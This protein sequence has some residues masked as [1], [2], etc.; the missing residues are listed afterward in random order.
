[1]PEV[2]G[3]RCP[4]HGRRLEWD[5]STTEAVPNR[6]GGEDTYRVT[7]YACPQYAECRSIHE[8]TD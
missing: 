7:R 3:F 1:M 5:E 4:V 2:H 8:V 6:W